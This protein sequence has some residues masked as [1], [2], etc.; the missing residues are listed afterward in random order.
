[1]SK[2]VALK[3]AKTLG[4]VA[5]LLGYSASGMAYLLYKLPSAS[6]YT[7]FEI[8]KKSGGFRVIAA[9]IDSLKGLQ[10]ALADLLNECRAE[11]AT[12]RPRRPIAHGYRK[13]LSII[14]NAQS[15]KAR[16]YVL[17]LDLKDFFP[18]FN[19]G[20][21]RGFFLKDEDFA[22][23]PKVATILAQIACFENSLPQG[24]PCSPVIADM[25]GHILDVRLLKLA[26]THRVTY[27]R[28]ADDLTFSTN[29]KSFPRAL[30]SGGNPPKTPW[31]LGIELT[32]IIQGAGFTINPDK[33]RM[34]VR[35]SLQ[36]VTGLTVNKKVNISQSYWRS[37]RSMCWA[38]F[39]TGA[40]HLP[41]DKGPPS[42]MQ[43]SL[44]PLEGILSHIYNVKRNSGDPPNPKNEDAIFGYTIHFRF[45][46][47]RTFVAPTRPVIICEG[48]TDNV[49]LRNAIRRLASFHPKLGGFTASGGFRFAVGLFNYSNQVHK[50]LGLR[51][52]SGPLLTLIN[53][54]QNNLKAY[55]V[56]PMA[57]PVIVLFDNDTGLNQSF[58]GQLK[59]RFGVN[60]SHAATDP[61]FRLTD[62]LYLVKTPAVAG[63]ATSCIE[64]LFD[65]TTLGMTLN[66]KTF[67]VD[68]NGFDP[69]KHIGKAPF[70]SKIVAPNAPTIS[71][72][73]FEPLLKRL[74]AVIDD[75]KPPGH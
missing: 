7:K 14:T 43:N 42:K 36:M 11:I 4:D 35:G 33:T 70:A 1:M 68:K 18:C 63:T 46:F 9:P 64:D 19:F 62:N 45:W 50:I 6:K 8:P 13:G 65:A 20:R 31:V 56:R 52:G 30:A 71:W 2:L 60:V 28:Y 47:Y 16:R 59:K 58:C 53:T 29:Q 15:H 39:S 51:G 61:F 17:N 21:V 37:A 27:S 24:S 49:Y 72:S 22:L 57:H 44:A 38:L 25:I 48:K 75:Y 32:S 69:T 26:K 74:T 55:K 66:G 73:G 67:H 12:A 5:V 23:D 54:Y 10:R 41:S 40:Y 34:Q 3:S